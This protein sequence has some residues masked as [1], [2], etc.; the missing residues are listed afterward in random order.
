MNVYDIASEFNLSVRKVRKMDQA[1]L[2]KKSTEEDT[3]VSKMTYSLRKGNRLS[4]INLAALIDDPNLVYELG[5]YSEAAAEQIRSLGNPK[6]EIGERIWA[7]VDFAAMDRPD[8][9]DAMIEWIKSVVP[10][11]RGVPYEYIAVR[12]LLAKQGGVRR[13]L[14]GKLPRA[15]LNCRKVTDFERWVTLTPNKYGHNATLFCRPGNAFDL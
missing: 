3:I 6:D 7:R 1:G 12:V 10:A 5:P 2:F 8:D 11:N 14:A 9:V 4:A 15:I 13:Y